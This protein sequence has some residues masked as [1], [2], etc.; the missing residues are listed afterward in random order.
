MAIVSQ[1]ASARRFLRICV[2]VHVCASAPSLQQHAYA[3]FN[4]PPEFYVCM[5]RFTSPTYTFFDWFTS[6]SIYVYQIQPANRSDKVVPYG[7]WCAG[8]QSCEWIGHYLSAL[9]FASS[10][11]KTNASA[12]LRS[13]VRVRVRVRLGF[14]L[15]RCTARLGLGLAQFRF[16]AHIQT[17]IDIMHAH[18]DARTCQ[19]HLDI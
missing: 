2:C 18:I 9:A 5:F 16:W 1:Q 7:G 19:L 3:C 17:C 4:P 14:G 15:G 10:L 13:K 6:Q 12:A 11:D 8:E